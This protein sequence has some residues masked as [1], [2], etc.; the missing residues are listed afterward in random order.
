M[1]LE[2]VLI[3]GGG[4]ALVVAEAA[5][6]VGTRVLGVYDDAPSPVATFRLNIPRLGPLAN[7]TRAPAPAILALGDL[8]ARRRIL[9]HLPRS[10]TWAEPVVHPDAVLHAS[11]TLAQGVYIGPRAIVHSFAAVAAH[12]ILNSACLVEHECRVGE[13]THL[14]PG[15]LLGGR[16]TVGLD[17]LLGLGSRI[18]PNLSVGDRAVVGGGALVHRCIPDDTT[19]VGVPAEPIPHRVR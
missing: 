6:L 3:G 5:A 13:N 8:A 16:V 15:T 10:F 12:A 7:A 11:A 9:D 1:A 4:H 17:T 2:I 14:A 19:V 18:L